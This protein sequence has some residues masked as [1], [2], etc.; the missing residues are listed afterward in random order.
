MVEAIRTG[1]PIE[2]S[3]GETIPA[4]ALRQ[5]IIHAQQ[6]IDPRGLEIVGAQIDGEFDLSHVVFPMPLLIRGCLIEGPVS[7]DGATISDI[8]FSGT[9]VGSLRFDGAEIAGNAIFAQGFAVAGEVYGRSAQI[10]GDLIL[11]DAVL[12]NRGDIA[13]GLDGTSVAG[14]FRAERLKA[15]G[16]VRAVGLKVGGQFVL[17]DAH[18]TN[19]GGTA[20]SLDGAEIAAGLFATEGFTAVGKV[21]AVSARIGHWTSFAGARVIHDGDGSLALDRA[22]LA[23]LLDLRG[24]TLS[25]PEGDALSLDHAQINGGVWCSEGF[26]A[27]G[28]LR[29]DGMQVSGQL[30]LTDATLSNPGGTA[31]SLQAAEISGGLFA[32]G[33]F[34]ASG[35]IRAPHLRVGGQLDMTD[36][37]LTNPSGWSMWLDGA[38]IE[39]NMFL[40][41][42][43]SSIGEFRAIGLKVSGQMIVAGGRLINSG[44][45]ALCLMSASIRN[46]ILG[47]LTVEGGIDLTRISIK[48]LDTTGQLPEPLTATGWD[49]DDLR[50]PLHNNW[51]AA[52]QWLAS[53]PPD[54]TSV[55]PWHELAAVYERNGNPTAG[56][57][58]RFLAANR[59]TSQSPRKQRLTG[60]LYRTIAG[61][62][63]YPGRAA[64]WLAGLLVLT[65]LIVANF[66]S[67]IVPIRTADALA[68]VQKHSSQTHAPPS[69]PV[70]AA[71]PCDWHPEYPCMNT[72]SFTLTNLLPTAGISPSP[73]DWI[74]RSDSWLTSVLLIAKF[75]AWGLAAL[76]LAGVTGWLKK[77]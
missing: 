22:N 71:T 27:I 21:R 33:E 75:G 44:N 10:G 30:D 5:F 45:D 16:E 32:R 1:E 14:S 8:N 69:D 72:L 60:H 39:G 42:G 11:D 29:A 70:T 2:P 4:Q 52:D 43:F 61:H 36:A 12:L 37:T 9:S 15:V 49:I 19:E 40:R 63:Y 26:R 62:G 51:R 56:R 25:N 23:G 34:H 76:L 13:L 67:E 58:L 55:Q 18:L 38:N 31:L 7:L 53:A 20:L 68:S 35:G 28:Q 6:G 74:S 17:N 66:R 24:A 57:R 50:G 77:T 73:P 59:L 65:G 46:M 47:S 3:D 54:A 64:G 48:D 41:G